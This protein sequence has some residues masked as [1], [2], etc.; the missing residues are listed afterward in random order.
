MLELGIIR[1]STSVFSSQVLLVHKR[2]ES[3]RFCVNYRALNTKTIRDK[4]PIPVVEELL[5]ELKGVVFFTKLDLRSG[6]HQVR[7]HPDDIHKTAFRTH[8]SHFE[9]LVMPFGL[10]D[11]SATFH[12]LMNAILGSF[13][14]RCVIIFFDDILIFS[15]T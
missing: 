3:W 13:L 9:F 15:R 5:D 10:T 2:D 12:T 8:H 11:A 1:P 14:R 7:M 4:F 6:Y